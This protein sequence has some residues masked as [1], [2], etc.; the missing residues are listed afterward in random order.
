MSELEYTEQ[1]WRYTTDTTRHHRTRGWDYSGVGIYHVTLVVAERYPLFGHLAGDT[2]DE[3]HIELNAFGMLVL[4][5]LRDEPR[6]YG[7][8]GYTFKILASMVMPDHVHVAIQVLKPLPKSIGTVIRGF[9]S[10]CTS[11]YKQANATNG[12][13]YATKGEN[14]GENNGRK[15]ATKGENAG[16]SNIPFSRIFTRIGSIWQP[17]SAYYH[18][19][20]IHGYC[21]IDSLIRYIKA[22]PRRL[23]LKRANP[24]LFKI[25]QQYTI[26]GVPCTVLG[27][28]FL[29]EQPMRAMVQC[30]RKLT[31]A[32]IEARRDE[33]LNAAANG[34]IHVSAA[35][36]EGEK[37][38]C[39]ALREASFPLIIL[40][41]EGFPKP[42][43]PHYKYYKPQ[44]VYFEA[45][46]AGRLL[47]VEPS[48][49]LYERPEIEAK[50]YAKTGIHDLPH[51]SQRYRFLALNAL[52]GKIAEE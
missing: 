23:A 3:A 2:P 16:E 24:D 13:K 41:T 1:G 42:D 19:R 40:L 38:I 27:N 4:E 10:A 46:A 7:E 21:Q 48:A 22:N 44:G 15:Y 34:V 5:L 28:M 36:S 31:Q 47:L 43:S 32:E 18:E 37:Q 50:V 20:I 30:S 14:V 35:I 51:T 6:Y 45:C 49:E 29:A 12:R 26:A 33:C 9:K 8:T 52:A 39:R 25:H 17:D 11:L